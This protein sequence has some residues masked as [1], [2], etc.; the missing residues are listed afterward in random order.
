LTAK[1]SA[2]LDQL[3]TRPAWQADAACLDAPAPDRFFSDAPANQ[4]A[5]LAVCEACP[6]TEACLAYAIETDSEG[7]WGGTTSAA[8][9]K[10][11]TRPDNECSRGHELNEETI[12]WT[13]GGRWRVC[14]VCERENQ[15]ERQRKRTAA[16]RA[17]RG[18]AA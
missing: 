12:R 5:A 15:Q 3:T 10:P 8:R 11:K 16:R 1:G 18:T 17:G 2:L 13:G 7:V 9:R 6:V 4:T 14:R